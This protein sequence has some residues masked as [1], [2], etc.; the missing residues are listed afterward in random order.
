LDASPLDV[1][2][3][4][5]IEAEHVLVAVDEVEEVIPV[6]LLLVLLLYCCYQSNGCKRQ[7]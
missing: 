4:D 1:F 7:L 6:I 3:D 5:S 2:N